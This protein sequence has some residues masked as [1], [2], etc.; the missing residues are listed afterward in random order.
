MMNISSVMLSNLAA[1]VILALAAV[2][3]LVMFSL[4]KRGQY[5]LDWLVIRVPIFGELAYQSI[6]GRFCR[7]LGLLLASSVPVLDSFTLVSNAVG[8]LLFRDAILRARDMVED[9]RGIMKALQESTL[10]PNIVTQLIE[11]GEETGEIE[12]MLFKAAEYYEKQVNSLIERI[13][14]LIEPILII[15]LA[16]VV[17]GLVVVIY[18]PIFNLGSAMKQGLQ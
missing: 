18:L 5:V 4:T 1:T 13:T 11:T 14:S 8:N 15:L 17:G 10:F 16:L 9:G 7:T 2:A 3:G 12:A 6:V